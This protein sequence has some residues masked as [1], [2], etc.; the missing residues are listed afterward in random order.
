MHYSFIAATIIPLG[1]AMLKFRFA[2]QSVCFLLNAA[3]YLAVLAS[4]VAM[5]L[6]PYHRGDT[7]KK[8]R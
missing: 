1:D 2:G 6:C 3:S 4:L 8:E 5:R 7:G